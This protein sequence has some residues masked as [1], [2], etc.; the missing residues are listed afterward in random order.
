MED[1]FIVILMKMVSNTIICSNFVFRLKR[2]DCFQSSGYQLGHKAYYVLK[3]SDVVITRK[4]HIKPCDVHEIL[5]SQGLLPSS[6][7][8]N[9]K[10]IQET[11]VQSH[12]TDKIAEEKDEICVNGDVVMEDIA[13]GNCEV[14][15]INDSFKCS[16]SW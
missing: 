16:V 6:L 4:H 2:L 15:P 1:C 11:V 12:E 10:L 9:Q 5:S 3:D 7:A 8:F 14:C 13:N